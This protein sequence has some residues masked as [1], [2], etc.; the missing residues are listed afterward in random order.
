M[1]KAKPNIKN[2]TPK[3][4]TEKPSKHAGGRP[5]KFDSGMIEQVEKLCMLGAT[6]KEI[7]DF[8]DI[9]ESTLNEWKHTFPE[10]SESIKN[11]KIKAD[12]N[13]A[14]SLY[15]RAMGYEHDEDVIFNDKGTPLVVATRKHYPPDTTAMI[16][17]LKNRRSQNWRD[18][19]DL[20][21]TSGGNTLNP[22]TI[23][24]TDEETKDELKKLR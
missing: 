4:E 8:F 19:Q 17:W 16:F 14:D 20:D 1:A 3:T 11:G 23:I 12:L 6:D 9:S 22:W 2:R 10:F 24:T 18:K 21:L 15:K 13:V 5:T 7:A